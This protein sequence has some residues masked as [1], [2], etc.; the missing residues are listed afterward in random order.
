MSRNRK[1][2]I[3]FISIVT[4]LGIALGVCCLIVVLGVMSGFDNN[5]KE[6]LLGSSFHLVA[7]LDNSGQVEFEKIQSV[8][9]V[10]SL[11]E[12]SQIQ[13][14]VKKDKNITPV[15]FEGLK[16]NEAEE[17]LW[18][19]YLTDGNFQG[20]AIGRIL[21]RSL[22]LYIGDEVEVFNPKTFKPKKF[23]V[24]GI[25]SFG[26]Y[27]LDANFVV[28]PLSEARDFLKE[29]EALFALGIR[30]D[31]I[32]KAEPIKK[33]I[34]DRNP[35]GIYLIKTWAELNETLFSAL[36]LEKITMFVILNLII[37]VA[38]FNIFAT[39]TVKVVEKVKDIGI[40]KSL[41]MTGWG[42]NL[43]FCLQGIFLGL[44]GTLLG[45]GAGIGICLFL[46]KYHLKVLPAKIYSIDYLPVTI[47]YNDIASV[48]IVALTM[49]FIFSL[50]PSIRASKIKEIEALRYE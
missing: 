39:Q 48:C 28:Y 19:T 29:V 14:A 38:S 36:Q 45:S 16:F 24:S 49:S 40:L 18:K 25:F 8:E 13:T 12:F 1:R 11:V 5:L 34:L 7:Y 33:A 26:I 35:K 15:I 21:A 27:D 22:D 9:G 43:L 42:I 37:L 4:C 46:E 47:D 17:A 2:H 23:K 44:L 6:K 32:Y 41:G 20:L 10:K 3:S 50:M 30:V 31:D